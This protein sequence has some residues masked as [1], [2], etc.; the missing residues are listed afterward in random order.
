FPFLLRLFSVPRITMPF[1]PALPLPSALFFYKRDPPSNETL[2]LSHG[3]RRGKVFRFCR[4]ALS[5]VSSKMRRFPGAFSPRLSDSCRRFQ[6]ALS[7]FCSLRIPA[8]R[9]RPPES[10]PPA[11]SPARNPESPLPH[12][13]RSVP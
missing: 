9:D 11:L 8:L 2:S 6:E 4:T 5:A 1:L 12:S 7:V 13:V 10:P 3:P